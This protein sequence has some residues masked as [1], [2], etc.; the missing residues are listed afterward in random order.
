MLFSSMKQLTVHSV[1]NVL[2]YLDSL[3]PAGLSF[4][5][6][7]ALNAGVPSELSYRLFPWLV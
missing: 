7:L 3:L 6:N 5:S 1:K 2:N 4:F